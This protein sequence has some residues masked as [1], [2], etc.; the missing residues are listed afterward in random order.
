MSLKRHSSYNA[1]AGRSILSSARA[2]VQHVSW[3]VNMG[4]EWH[5]F[6]GDM[7]QT[8]EVYSRRKQLNKK[9][10]LKQKKFRNDFFFSIFNN[11]SPTICIF[12]TPPPPKKRQHSAKI[13]N[14]IAAHMW[15]EKKSNCRKMQGKS[16]TQPS[17]TKLCLFVCLFLTCKSW[18]E[19]H[20]STTYNLATTLSWKIKYRCI[21]GQ[22]SKCWAPEPT[23]TNHCFLFIFF[24]FKRHP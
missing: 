18:Q 12:F 2:G 8:K 19:M 3:L 15:G 23:R 4:D 16:N 6:K 24:F 10:Q 17:G 1:N 9:G 21:R 5:C 22:N 20:V 13:K 14:K 7:D 11:K